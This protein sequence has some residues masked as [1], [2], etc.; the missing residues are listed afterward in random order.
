MNNSVNWEEIEQT[1]QDLID[2]QK[3]ILLKNAK[4]IVPNVIADDLMQPNDFPLL[5]NN[6]LF[7]YEE[8]CLAGM[9][10][11]EM[12]LKALKKQTTSN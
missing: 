12:A 10:S 7:R 3:S 4:Q 1:V 9:Q 5:E 6:A 2:Y 8:G 11:I